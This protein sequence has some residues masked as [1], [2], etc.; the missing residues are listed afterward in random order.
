MRKWYLVL[1]TLSALVVVGGPALA[2]VTNGPHDAGTN[3]GAQGV[4]SPCHLPHT[5]MD[6]ARLWPVTPSSALTPGVTPS[7]CASCHYGT[8][9]YQGVPGFSDARTTSSNVFGTYSHGKKMLRANI[10]PGENMAAQATATNPLPYTDNGAAIECTSCHNVHS[11]ANRPFLRSN[12]DTL[13]VRCHNAASGTQGRQFT[14]DAISSGAVGWGRSHV[15][16]GNP[17]SHPVGTDITETLADATNLHPITFPPDFTAA[18]SPAS[19]SDSV[20]NWSLGGHLLTASSV[21]CVTCHAVHGM[22]RDAQDSVST[23]Y[24]THDTSPNMLVRDQTDSNYGATTPTTGFST[25]GTTTS[26]TIANG[27]N[28]VGNTFCE[29]CHNAATPIV[30]TGYGGSRLV[31]PGN[32]VGTHPVDDY[33]PLNTAVVG[34]L[35]AELP[36][37]SVDSGTLG[38]A[39]ICES[40]HTPHPAAWNPAGPAESRTGIWA[41]AGPY[42]L[43]D[44]QTAICGRCHTSSFTRHHPVGRDVATAVGTGRAAAYLMSGMP[45]GSSTV[46]TCGMCHANGTGGAHNWGG[47]AAVS[48]NANWRPRDNGRN[49]TTPI[50]DRFFTDNN[51][52]SVSTTCVDCHLDLDGTSG[53]TNLSPTMTT[54]TAGSLG[55][56]NTEDEYTYL[57][58]GSHYLGPFADNFLNGNKTV[59]STSQTINPRTGTWTATIFGTGNAAGGWSRFGGTA[60]DPLLVCESCHELQPSQNV[61]QHML[62]SAFREGQS[63]TLAYASGYD[64]FCEACHAKPTGTHPMTTDNVGRTG[65]LLNTNIDTATR[66][67][68]VTGSPKATPTGGAA[69]TSTWTTG[70]PAAGIMTC[71]SCHQVHDANTQGASLIIEAPNANVTGGTVQAITATNYYG[72][73]AIANRLR[74]KDP[75]F[76]TGKGT[77]PDVSMFCDQCHGYRQ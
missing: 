14:N 74:E 40:C 23:A 16:N 32:T 67:W 4:C 34:A 1:V 28:T 68:L 20:G 46:L 48:M 76:A 13:C 66:P 69:G 64:D 72:G 22:A 29:A 5:G 57:G 12:M 49:Y 58:S 2:A 52:Y 51:S 61:G 33:A 25:E 39:A 27:H 18:I 6:T 53:A 70:G 45:T 59:R 36:Q 41:G 26:R 8:G 9:A 56:D 30:P 50:N 17:G 62:L 37:S 44:S 7:L 24:T 65:Q 35:P 43:R 75:S 47:R 10:P 11:D 60:T 54:R 77:M 42:I 63:E 19:T 38:K 73:N 3:T 15:G 55:T 71:E 21:G 31:N